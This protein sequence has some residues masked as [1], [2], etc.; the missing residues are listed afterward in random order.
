MTNDKWTR[1]QRATAA[2][3]ARAAL[4][5][6]IAALCQPLP[7][8]PQAAATISPAMLAVIAATEAKATAPAVQ[9][10]PPSASPVLVPQKATEAYH[11]DAKILAELASKHPDSG[12]NLEVMKRDDRGRPEWIVGHDAHGKV[13]RGFAAGRDFP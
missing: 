3:D 4:D 12:H 6:R 11:G 9:V 13:V 1:V 5:L 10:P 7:P 2:L 8:K